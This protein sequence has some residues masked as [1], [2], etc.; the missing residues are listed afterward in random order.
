MEKLALEL[1]LEVK[2]GRAQLG[3]IV[4]YFEKHTLVES[5]E[6]SGLVVSFFKSVTEIVPLADGTEEEEKR[7]MEMK[8]FIEYRDKSFGCKIGVQHNAPLLWDIFWNIYNQL[9]PKE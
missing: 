6:M 2:G 7:E 9:K 8:A 3:D 5:G 1:Q 4:A